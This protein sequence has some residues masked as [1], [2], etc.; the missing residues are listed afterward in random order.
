MLIKYYEI[1]DILEVI[2]NKEKQTPGRRYQ[3]QMLLQNLLEL[4]SDDFLNAG[5]KML[6]SDQIRY[7]VKFVFSKY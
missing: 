2:G 1:G 7:S 5:Q 6:A 3:V 4:D